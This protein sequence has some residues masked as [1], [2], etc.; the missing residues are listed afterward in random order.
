VLNFGQMLMWHIIVLPLAIGA[1]VVVHVLLVRRHGVVRPLP[2][3]PT[4]LPPDDVSA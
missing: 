2:T 1:L 3:H 4:V